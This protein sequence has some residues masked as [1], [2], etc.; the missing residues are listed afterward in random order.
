MNEGR[1]DDNLPEASP[2]AD[3]ATDSGDDLDLDRE[4]ADPGVYRVEIS[5]PD[6]GTADDEPPEAIPVRESHIVDVPVARPLPPDAS[7]TMPRDPAEPV[8][9]AKVVLGV[10]LSFLVFSIAFVA[11]YV[12]VQLSS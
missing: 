2:V 9:G 1:D 11:A 8:D 6:K 10:F 7:A 4:Y 3:P 5:V 12:Y